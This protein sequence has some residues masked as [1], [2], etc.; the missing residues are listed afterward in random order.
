MV[1]KLGFTYLAHRHCFIAEPNRQIDLA[2]I[3]QNFKK[4]AAVNSILDGKIVIA[5]KAH[6]AIKVH[7]VAEA[8][9]ATSAGQWL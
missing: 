4:S 8:N 6:R 7:C 1:L 2:Q 5:W 3:K 9:N